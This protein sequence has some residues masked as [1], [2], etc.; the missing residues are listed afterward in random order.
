[1]FYHIPFKITSDRFNIFIYVK[2]LYICETTLVSYIALDS[3][4]KEV[5]VFPRSFNKEELFFF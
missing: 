4:D 3:E 5:V 1:M 2:L